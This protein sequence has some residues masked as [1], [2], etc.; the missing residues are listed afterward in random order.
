M[1]PTETWY[2]HLERSGA[3][4]FSLCFHSISP[5]CYWPWLQHVPLSSPLWAKG[6]QSG[7]G[8]LQL[9]AE[10]WRDALLR[11]SIHRCCQDHMCNCSGIRWS[12]LILPLLLPLLLF[13]LQTLRLEEINLQA[14]V[15][16]NIRAS[17]TAKS[18]LVQ[19]WTWALRPCCPEALYPWPHPSSLSEEN[20]RSPEHSITEK[21]EGDGI[22]RV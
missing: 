12:V 3:N 19:K 10:W 1:R 6:Q 20:K 13:S 14:Y 2:A 11:W 5:D 7:L 18:P 4:I 15:S 16:K 22:W 9:C 17:L 8:G 21:G